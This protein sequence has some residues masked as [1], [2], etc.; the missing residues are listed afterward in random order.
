VTLDQL[1]DRETLL[2]AAKLL[3]AENLVMAKMIAKLK[4]RLAVLEGTEA[5]QLKLQIEDLEADLAQARKKL[6]GES[7]ERRKPPAAESAPAEEPKR[8]TGHGRREQPKLEVVERV[9]VQS[10]EDKCE[11]CGG[12][13]K[14]WAGQFEESEEIDIIERRFVVTKHK[15]QKY[16]CNCGSCIKAAP[17]PVK[18][19]DGA[20]YSVGF[21]VHVAMSK[22][23]D[24]LPL[25]RQVKTMGRDGLTIDSQTLW[26]QIEALGRL[27]Q[28]AHEA[29]ADY[30][31]EQ[32]VIGADETH[33]RLMGEK[34]KKEGGAGKQWHVWAL[35][36]PD[37]VSYRIEDSRSAEAAAR[38]LG[39]YT[40]TVL[41]DGY[42]AYQSLKKRGEKFKLAHCWA[43]VRRK[44]V[45]IEEQYPKECGE[46]LDLIGKLYQV[47]RDT[48]DGPPDKRLETRRERS[49]TL[50]TEIQNWALRTEALPQSNL[51]K[52]IAYMGG[53]WEGLRVFLDDPDVELDNNRTERAIRGVVVG[54]KNHYG[55][56]SR[57][58]TEVAALFYSLIES[59]K[60]AGV[61]PHTYLKI[62]TE[63]A[64]R[65][66]KIQLPH[67]VAAAA[68]A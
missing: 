51:G 21:A 28:P 10:A 25:E 52:A 43:H 38:V 12:E 22:Y 1:T 61:G 62:A 20:R 59:A 11:V 44:F 63:A 5:V 64:L 49:R 19:F 39:G 16:R 27:L 15:R 37:A 65:G 14:E 2:K 18:L 33:W 9:H 34:G 47:E 50:L 55:S 48:R 35:A 54:R 29:L 8:Q 41:T 58:G 23:A 57:R 45:E 40:G 36:A 66:A 31:L 42:G 13:T 67:E 30:V 3:E 68:T 32:P 53:V 4:K 24:H 26:D 46:V 17:G 7:T 6:F 60:L 56:R